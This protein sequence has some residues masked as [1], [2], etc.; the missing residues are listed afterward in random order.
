MIKFLKSLAPIPV[1]IK[2]PE[3]FYVW[4]TTV[5]DS[6]RNKIKR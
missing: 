3:A 1:I 4:R 2:Y 6:L 5:S